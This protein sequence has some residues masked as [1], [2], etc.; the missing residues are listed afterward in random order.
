M[1]PFA[2]FHENAEPMRN[3]LRMHRDALDAI[4]ASLVPISLMSAAQEAWNE[5]V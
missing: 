1:G 3:V 4:D 2:G 5:A